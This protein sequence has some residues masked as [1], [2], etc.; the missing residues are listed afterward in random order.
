[1]RT[2]SCSPV[3]SYFPIFIHNTTK[4]WEFP[5]QICGC[6][7]A[8]AQWVM[9][10]LE[11]ASKQRGW[12]SLL[13]RNAGQTFLWPSLTTQAETRLADPVKTH[14]SCTQQGSKHVFLCVWNV[15]FRWSVNCCGAVTITFVRSVITR[16]QDTPTQK[17]HPCFSDSK[18]GCSLVENLRKSSPHITCTPTFSVIFGPKRWI[19][20]VG[21]YGSF[22]P[23]PSPVKRNCATHES[24]KQSRSW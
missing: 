11:A 19:L 23:V 13:A 12:W 3:A 5:W 24:A 20:C 1:M 18:L 22:L 4:Q 9:W 17:M 15:K 16:I 6:F 8:V 14:A 10:K 7:Q 21:N 2:G